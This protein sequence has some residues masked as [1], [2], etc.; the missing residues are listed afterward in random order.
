MQ[1]SGSVQRRIATP[2]A[3]AA[4]A[5]PAA[6]SRWA[7]L[8]VSAV[9]EADAER[10][11]VAL[12]EDVPDLVA[13]LAIERVAEDALAADEASMDVADSEMVLELSF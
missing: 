9:E 3:T 10:V 7:P 8:S 2:A 11:A 6:V 1:S 13:L 5:A 12:R 4:A